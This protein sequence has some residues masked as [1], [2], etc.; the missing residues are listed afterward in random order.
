MVRKVEGSAWTKVVLGE[1]GFAGWCMV[2][3]V[4]EGEAMKE[5]ETSDIYFG[6]FYKV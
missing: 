2:V 6:C 1:V 4:L 5:N 3:L